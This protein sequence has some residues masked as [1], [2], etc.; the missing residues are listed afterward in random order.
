MKIAVVNADQGRWQFQGA[1]Q[2][3]AVMGLNENI[4]VPVR[5]HS[6]KFVGKTIIN[7]R[8][9]QKNAVCAPGTCFNHLIG[10][11]HEILAQSG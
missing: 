3:I 5:G 8:H 11:K 7:H 4:E 10:V 6:L 9:D 1:V 2:L